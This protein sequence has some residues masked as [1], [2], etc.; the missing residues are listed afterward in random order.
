FREITLLTFERLVFDGILQEVVLFC[1]VVGA[2]P[3]QIRTVN[4]PDA[5][6]LASIVPADLNVEHLPS[7]PALMHEKEKWTKYFL[8]PDAIQLLRTLKQSGDMTR[9]GCIA[10]VDVGIVTGRNSFF[11]FTDAQARELG[12]GP[13]CV[14]LVS[15][16]TQLS[17]L[18]YDTDCRACDVA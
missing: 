8:D 9:L 2:G 18:V 7:A 12:L 3:A 6:A 14:P 5:A 4:L 10:D 11:T 16:S 1:G 15:R 17:G 13:H